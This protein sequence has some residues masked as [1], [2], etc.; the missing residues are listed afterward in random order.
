M[1]IETI[2]KADLNEFLKSLLE[3]IRGILKDTNEQPKKW[4]KSTE[5]RKLLN[6][7]PGTLQPLHINR[8]L[9]YTKVW[10]CNFYSNATIEKLSKVNKL[11]THFSN[12]NNNYPPNKGRISL[13]TLKTMNYL[14]HLTEFFDR[15]ILDKSIN[16]THISLYMVLFQ[17]W[18]INQF[19]SPIT[20]TR[21]EVMQ[22]SKIYSKA[23]YHKC[24]KELN[25]KGYVKYE[26]SFNPYKGS[27]VYLID[28][29]I[30]DNIIKK[31]NN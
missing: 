3:D 8:T 10:R 17:F 9:S 31:S 7:S 14:K 25:I 19:K 29:T 13:F 28:F 4:L 2:A 11:H 16:P 21:D 23:T 5:E 27:S 30:K 20:I 12:N 24:M 6:I 26:P 22:I 18:N 1:A 15:T